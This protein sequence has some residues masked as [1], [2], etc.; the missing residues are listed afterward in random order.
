VL[1]QTVIMDS[2]KYTI[3]SSNDNKENDF[4]L[5]RR[6]K[7]GLLIK[8]E[9]AL[10]DMIQV[11]RATEHPRA[12]EVLS[13]MLKNVSDAGDSLIDIHKKKHDME[14]KDVP[15]LPTTNN[16]VFVGSTTDLQRMLMKDVEAIEH[17]DE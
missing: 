7:H 13:G 9:E 17:K 11:A 2:R 10:E 4:E 5:V 8:G 14:K 15:A 3:M 12:Y 16:N 6:I 1:V